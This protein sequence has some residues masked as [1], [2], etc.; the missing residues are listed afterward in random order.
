MEEKLKSYGKLIDDRK[1]INNFAE[2][3]MS[4]LSDVRNGM[5]IIVFSR[6]R[7]NVIYMK[8]SIL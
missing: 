8:I 7:L 3:T 5:T 6:P 4:H 2:A 1:G